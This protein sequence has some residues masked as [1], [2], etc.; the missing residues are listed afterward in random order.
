MWVSTG[1]PGRALVGTCKHTHLN[2]F[3]E[4]PTRAPPVDPH[5]ILIPSTSVITERAQVDR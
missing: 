3:E 2:V 5:T 1:G 4:V